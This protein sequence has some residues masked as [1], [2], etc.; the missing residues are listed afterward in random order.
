MGLS[1]L[2]ILVASGQGRPAVRVHSCP[3]TGRELG[4]VLHTILRLG[5]SLPASLR[6]DVGGPHYAAR[7][8]RLNIGH[9]A[10]NKIVPFGPLRTAEPA[11]AVP[12]A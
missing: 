10:D 12:D 11:Q 3:G 4:V 9:D 6:L 2:G 8:R 7:D 1:G 5:L